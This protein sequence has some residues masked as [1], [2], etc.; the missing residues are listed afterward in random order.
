[1]ARQLRLRAKGGSYSRVAETKA[2][3]GGLQA[4]RAHLWTLAGVCMRLANA[5]TRQLACWLQSP[6]PLLL[7]SADRSSWMLAM[8]RLG[9]RCGRDCCGRLGARAAG[10]RRC[11]HS[12][13]GRWRHAANRQLD[14]GHGSQHCSVAT[15]ATLSPIGCCAAALHGPLAL[16]TGA[17]EAF[18]SQL[19]RNQ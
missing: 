11:V 15:D 8:E 12:A 5:E 18:V 17:A 10:W 19:G 2:A 1:M 16:S 7:C 4:R 3:R 14:S 13:A 6:L 9:D